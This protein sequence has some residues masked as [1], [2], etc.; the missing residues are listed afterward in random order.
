MADATLSDPLGRE[1]VPHDH[2]WHGHI[3]KFH[4]EVKDQR[5][6][7]EQAIHSP[8]QIRHSHS[9]PGCRLRYGRCPTPSAA[10]CPRI[11]LSGLLLSRLRDA[12]G[13]GRNRSRGRGARAYN[14]RTARCKPVGNMPISWRGAFGRGRAQ[15]IIGA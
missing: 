3:V 14:A 8:D 6:L 5:L 12:R 11:L 10:A 7:V 13:L 2:T 1:I 4:A 15:P 9:D